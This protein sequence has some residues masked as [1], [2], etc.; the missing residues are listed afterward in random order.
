V[1]GVEEQ[2]VV[3]RRKENAI[4]DTVGLG[5]MFLSWGDAIRGETEFGLD[6]LKRMTEPSYCSRKDRRAGR[7]VTGGYRGIWEDKVSRRGNTRKSK[8]SVLGENR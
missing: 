3:N 4:G 2:G 1:K 6:N 5:T 8:A 7:N